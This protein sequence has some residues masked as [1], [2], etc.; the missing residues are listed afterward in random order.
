MP[1]LLCFDFTFGIVLIAV[2]VQGQMPA[3]QRSRRYSLD[4]QK[5]ASRL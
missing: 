3:H 1:F 2:S 5:K 4:Q